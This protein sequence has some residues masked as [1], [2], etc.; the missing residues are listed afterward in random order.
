MKLCSECTLPATYS[1]QKNG[2]NKPRLCRKHWREL[3]YPETMA[4]KTPEKERTYE[5]ISRDATEYHRR[6]T[7]V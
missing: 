4:P 1:Y 7:G 2:I 3:V 6:R 5:H